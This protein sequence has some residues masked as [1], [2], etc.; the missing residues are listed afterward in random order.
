MDASPLPFVLISCSAVPKIQLDFSL[1]SL[2]DCDVHGSL[3]IV[4]KDV[5]IDVD[6]FLNLLDNVGVKLLY[7]SLIIFYFLIIGG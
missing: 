2:T 7:C 4:K 6:C 5:Q 1:T 3:I